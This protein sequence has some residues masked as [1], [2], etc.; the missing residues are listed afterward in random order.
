MGYVLDVGF[1]IVILLVVF[2]F[3]G[4]ALGACWRVG[5]VVPTVGGVALIYWLQV[6]VKA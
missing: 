6:F 3:N 2:V 5:C 4:S 1:H